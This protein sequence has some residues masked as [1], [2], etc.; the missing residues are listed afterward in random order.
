MTT[1]VDAR[2]T[3]A[4]SSGTTGG[5]TLTGTGLLL[6]FALR[7]DRV[8]LLVWLLA[9]AG[10]YA[11][12]LSEYVILDTD[13][14][15]REA[16]AGLMR[17]PAMIA[18]S[19]PG[20][21][22]DDY[23]FGP[24]VANE[25]IL[26]V[27][28]TLSVLS[29]L[30]I[31]RHTRAEEESSR[32]E[33]VRAGVVGRHA[34]AVAAMLELVIAQAAIAVVSGA[35]LTAQGL[36]A[37]GS[38]AM[39]GAIALGALVFGP[40]AL[41]AGQLME[42]GRGAVGLSFA[43]LGA[44]YM[45]RALGDI[46]EPNGSI[47]S[48][49]SPIGWVQ[50]TR[51]FVDFRAWPLLLCVGFGAGLVVVSSVLASRRDFGAGMVAVRRGRGDARAALRSPFALAWTQQ[52]SA[53][54]W[55]S[56]GLG[57]MWFGTGAVLDAV[58]DIVDAVGDNP[59]YAALF[60]DADNLVRAFVTIIA[61]YAATGA[62]GYAVAGLQRTRSEEEAGRVEY[63]LATPVSRGRWLA[64]NL[65]VVGIG[66]VIVLLSGVVALGLGAASIGLSEPTFGEF[67]LV[68]L[69]YL[70]ALAVLIG[71]AAALFAW[72]PR[73]TPLAWAL[74]GYMFVAAMFAAL[75]DL[76]EWAQRISPFYWVDDPLSGDVVP[77]HVLGLCAVAV[78]LFGL[79]F[80]G[81]R[82]RDVPKA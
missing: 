42:H 71:F 17:T 70:P 65:A 47:L 5:T 69:V 38:F 18:M 35:V 14:Q 54:L 72:V 30:Q 45:L 9:V 68:G 13:A 19:G 8:R 59:L 40:V 41:V 48:W 64:A 46:Q 10:L 61:L 80:L 57:V 82:R 60:S 66:T 27:V 79:A 63:A 21:G 22:L 73:L 25:L 81:F 53:L 2:P 52:R 20:Y 24:A 56:L 76:P 34:P 26:W 16:R 77:A 1:L 43:A 51:V 44:A 6:R 23:R 50:Q 74:F 28:L 3:A 4:P 36:D 55:T 75:F 33:L 11:G 49:L 29:I 15:A 31:V 12:G 32:S 58:P 62:A 67:V 39:A 78:V 37:G 7:R